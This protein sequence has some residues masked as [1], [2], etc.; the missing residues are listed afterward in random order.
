MDCLIQLLIFSEFLC[1]EAALTCLLTYMCRDINT[2]G[3]GTMRDYKSH[4]IWFPN[5]IVHNIRYLDILAHP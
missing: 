5:Q 2:S 3:S 1:Q 4:L